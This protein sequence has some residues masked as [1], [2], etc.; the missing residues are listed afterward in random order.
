M[1]EVYKQYDGPLYIIPA[2]TG[3]DPKQITLLNRDSA[4]PQNTLYYA[5]HLPFYPFFIRLFSYIFGYLKSMIIVNVVGTILLAWTFYFILKRFQITRHPLL[6]GSIFLFLPRFLVVR[7]SGAPESIFLLC[8]I[9][10]LYFFE[11]KKYL[12]SSLIGFL[13]VATKTPGILLFAAYTFVFIE[14]YIKTKKIEK[15]WLWIFLIPVGLVAVFS[16]YYFQYNDFFAFFHT[17]GTVPMPYPFAVFNSS[18]KWVGSA[19]LEDVLFYFFLYGLTAYQFVTSKY[20]SFFYFSLVFGISLLFIQHRD[21]SRYSL[22]LWPLACMAFEH[23][24]TSKQFK[25]IFII[26]LLGIYMYTWNFLL[27][28][29]MPINEWLPFL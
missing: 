28:N 27:S 11:K 22:P 8:I 26:L 23:F 2:K 17:G 4:L 1:L 29:V 16:L 20:R 3:Y 12:L 13:A 9:S 21:I 6:L 19:W 24:F 5:A 18:A 15:S 10:S 25:I 7:S 14:T